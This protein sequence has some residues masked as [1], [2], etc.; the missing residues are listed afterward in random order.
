MVDI[1]IL[2]MVYKSTYNWGTQPCMDT[3]PAW[4]PVASRCQAWIDVHLLCLRRRGLDG[5]PLERHRRN[6]VVTWRWDHLCNMDI[7]G[8]FYGDFDGDCMVIV[9]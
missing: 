1:S 8:D 3:P 4:R 7:Y 2:T 9:W 6:N 5:H